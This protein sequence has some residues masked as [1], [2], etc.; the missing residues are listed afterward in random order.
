MEDGVGDVEQILRE[1]IITDEED[2]DNIIT[3]CFIF[4]VISIRKNAAQEGL[5][6]YCFNVFF[7]NIPVNNF[8]H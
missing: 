1:D 3:V 7:L 8:L 2:A 5:T 6:L 4:Q